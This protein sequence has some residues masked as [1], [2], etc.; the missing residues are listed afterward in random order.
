[1]PY[2]RNAELPAP[3]REALPPG[4]QDVF[5]KAFNHSFGRCRGRTSMALRAAWDAVKENYEEVHGHW[6]PKAQG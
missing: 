5:R 2:A 6:R 4:A 1:M 3:I